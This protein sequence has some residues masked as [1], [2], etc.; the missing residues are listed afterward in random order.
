VVVD[1]TVGQIALLLALF[2]QSLQA[3]FELFH[4][5]LPRLMT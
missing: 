1:L 3:V 5:S 2:E 4:Q